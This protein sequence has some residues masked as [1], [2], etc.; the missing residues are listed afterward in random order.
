MKEILKRK[1]PPM[2]SLRG[3]EA[4]AR[5]MSFSDAAEELQLTQGAISRQIKTLEDYLNLSLFVR[6]TRQVVLTPAGSE[7][8]RVV[9]EV[10]DQIEYATFQLRKK[11]KSRTLVISVLPTLAST[12]IMPRLHALTES[13]SELDLRIITS[14]EPVDLASDRVDIAVRVGRIPGRLYEERH[15]R[16]ELNMVQGWDGVIAEELFPD[17]LVPVCSPALLKS[18]RIDKPA[19]L[20]AFPLIHTTSRRFAWPDWLRAH[21][22]A[23]LERRKLEFGHFFMSLEAALANQGIA[24]V[25]QVILSL[26]KEAGRLKRL[27]E[28]SIHSAGA[29][30]LLSHESDARSHDVQALRQWI[31]SEAAALRT[32]CGTSPF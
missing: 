23:T 12:W 20:L 8:Y 29:Y 15:P 22:V 26:H 24:I 31:L 14:I 32:A 13:Q 9:R 17:I 18:R 5:H 11:S 4:A 27:F 1:L 6:K 3:F 19:D 30:Y 7:L 16:I 10:L 2:T 28:P 21:G 25:P